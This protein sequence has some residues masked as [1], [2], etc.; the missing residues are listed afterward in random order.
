M[1]KSR[2]WNR[3]SRVEGGLGTSGLQTDQRNHDDYDYR[4]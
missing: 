2:V 1:R 3:E 4:R